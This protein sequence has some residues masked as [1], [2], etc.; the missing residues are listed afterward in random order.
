MASCSTAA[1][2]ASTRRRS[3][4][5]AAASAAAVAAVASAAAAAAA[6]VAVGAAAVDAAAGATGTDRRRDRKPD[7]SWSP[8]FRLAWGAAYT[9]R[10]CQ[11][12]LVEQALRGGARVQPLAKEWAVGLAERMDIEVHA[13]GV[14]LVDWARPAVVMANHQSYLDVLALY[15]ALPPAFG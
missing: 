6:A 9:L 2:S 11:R 10:M 12:A 15:R 1:R 13:F 4:R 5:S 3:G 14:D 7:R 8:S